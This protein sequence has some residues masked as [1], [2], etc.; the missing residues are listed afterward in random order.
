VSQ[1]PRIDLIGLVVAD[2][3]ASLAFYRRLGMEL[4][5]EADGQPH[6]EVVL[7]GGVRLAWDTV[8]VVRSFDPEWQPPSGGHRVALAFDCGDPAGVDRAF[9]ELVDAGHAGHLPPWDAFWGQ[10]YAVVH[11]PDGNAVD[12]FAQTPNRSQ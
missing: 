3:A 10:R 8:D 2:M 9:G 6:V 7:P 5:A 12:L 4:P 1:V 11:D